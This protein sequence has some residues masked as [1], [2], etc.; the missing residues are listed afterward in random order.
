[1]THDANSHLYLSTIYCF[2]DSILAVELMGKRAL[3]SF[4]DAFGVFNKVILQ[5]KTTIMLWRGPGL[6]VC[7]YLT[8]KTRQGNRT[9]LPI[10]IDNLAP[11]TRGSM[12]ASDAVVRVCDGT[13][14][15]AAVE[16]GV[17]L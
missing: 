6:A 10:N 2:D 3:V 14:R 4:L 7:A 5:Q 17:P 12:W 11:L 9:L 1:M 8:F 13:R 15:G 16:S